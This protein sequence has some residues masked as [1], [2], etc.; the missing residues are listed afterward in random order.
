M[1]V[2]DRMQNLENIGL[3]VGPNPGLASSLFSVYT[4]NNENSI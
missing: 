1:A 3:S 2:P 4:E